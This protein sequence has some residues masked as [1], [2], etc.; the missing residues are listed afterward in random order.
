MICSFSN[1]RRLLP[2]LLFVK[3]NPRV[4]WPKDY[5][6]LNCLETVRSLFILSSRK[7]LFFLFC[8]FLALFFAPNNKIMKF[9]TIIVE[10]IAKTTHTPKTAHSALKIFP[11]TVVGVMSPY[12]TVVMVTV[13]NQNVAGILVK[14]VVCSLLSKKYITDENK[15]RVRNTHCRSSTSSF[16]LV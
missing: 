3:N 5:S 6:F 15:I 8:L 11:A 7:L 13:T 1:F 12:P 9:E 2:L 14:G 16:K 10:G 4:K